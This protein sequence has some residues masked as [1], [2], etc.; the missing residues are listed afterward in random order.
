MS[1]SDAITMAKDVPYPLTPVVIEKKLGQEFEFNGSPKITEVL[2]LVAEGDGVFSLDQESVKKLENQKL[3]VN[4]SNTPPPD[5]SSSRPSTEVT[6]ETS[7]AA[8]SITLV[9]STRQEDRDVSRQS[10]SSGNVHERLSNETGLGKS[11]K[12]VVISAESS[13]RVF[14]HPKFTRTLVEESVLGNYLRGPIEIRGRGKSIKIMIDSN[15]NVDISKIKKLGEFSV[16]AW[17]PISTKQRVGVISPVDVKINIES[18]F[19][20]FLQLDTNSANFTKIIE[21]KRLRKYVDL[22]CVKVV[23]EGEVLPEKV[24]FKNTILNFLT[25]C[26]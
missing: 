4:K 10:E 15:A 25:F 9:D 1:V 6:Q 7:S 14:Y 13:M 23:F 2:T 16:R 18:E 17:S 20:P 24:I 26:P 8:E 12:I 21:V 22:P 3:E 19:T 11:S 5:P